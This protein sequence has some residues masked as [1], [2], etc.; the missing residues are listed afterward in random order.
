MDKELVRIIFRGELDDFIDKIG[1]RG[2]Q[3][4]YTEAPLYLN[5]RVRKFFRDLTRRV[6][7]PAYLEMLL[8]DI[9]GVVPVY[10]YYQIEEQR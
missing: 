2:L 1:N 8:C 7:H 9:Y 6:T 3:K 10:E 5:N 4:A